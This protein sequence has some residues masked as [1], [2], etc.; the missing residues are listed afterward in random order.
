L[1]NECSKRG[2]ES[3]GRKKV[4][5]KVS[6]EIISQIISIPVSSPKIEIKQGV[7]MV[8]LICRYHCWHQNQ[9]GRGNTMKL[10]IEN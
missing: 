4:R 7:K 3:E 9:G 6:K 1:K 5:K 10:K 2:K 8:N